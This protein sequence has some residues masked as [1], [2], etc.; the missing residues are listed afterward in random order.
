LGPS[1]QAHKKASCVVNSATF[2]I[3]TTLEKQ[4]E[5]FA[6][7]DRRAADKKLHHVEKSHT[8]SDSSI[9]DETR[10]GGMIDNN[11]CEA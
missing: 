7:A 6:D 5:I 4:L 2:G 1:I 11:W 8:L 9:A 10:R 3:E